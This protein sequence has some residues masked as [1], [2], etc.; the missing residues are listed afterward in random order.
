MTPQEPHV[1][2]SSALVP[3]DIKD[4]GYSFEAESVPPN[5]WRFCLKLRFRREFV[6]L[7]VMYKAAN[8]P[9]GFLASGV[10]DFGAHVSRP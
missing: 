10:D 2:R 4:S 5:A 6:R 3:P 9:G 1:F 7:P 8:G